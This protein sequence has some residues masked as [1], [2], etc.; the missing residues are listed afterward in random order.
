MSETHP[1]RFDTRGAVITGAGKAFCVGADMA[2]GAETFARQEGAEF[3][4]AASW[5]CRCSPAT[6]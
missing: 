5:N 6:C 3:S 4:A 1:I 2:A